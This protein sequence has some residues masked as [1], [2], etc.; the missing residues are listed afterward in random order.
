MVNS[1]GIMQGRLSPPVDGQIQAFPLHWQ[2]EFARAQEAGLTA[3]EWLYREPV[4]G[5][6]NPLDLGETVA[7]IRHLEQQSGVRV[8]SVCA[9]YFVDHPLI[10]NEAVQWKQVDQLCVVIHRAAMLEVEYVVLPFVGRV[11]GADFRSTPADPA[12]ARGSRIHTVAEVTALVTLFRALAVTLRPL[13]LR[14]CLELEIDRRRIVALL[15]AV[16][17]PHFAVCYDLGDRAALGCDFVH[18]L[19]ELGPYLGAVHVKDR[20]FAGPTVPLGKGVVDWSE[21]PRSLRDAGYTGP[22]VLQEARGMPG[23]EVP[24]AIESREWL[25]AIWNQAPTP[26]KV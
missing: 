19:R 16:N 2:D 25:E 18:D 11:P 7:T 20:T 13:T 15:Q 5:D 23:K 14:I 6:R 10:V 17:D 1:L 26:G 8:R 9:D 21:V 3:I 4:D 12:W 24:W 22:L